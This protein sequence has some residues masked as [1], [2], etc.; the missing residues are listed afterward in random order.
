MCRDA[1]GLPEDGGEEPAIRAAVG[2]AS[3]WVQSVASAWGTD[4]V[5]SG[6]GDGTLKLWQVRWLRG[7]VHAGRSCARGLRPYHPLNSWLS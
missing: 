1:H 2:S 5:A 4:L 3:G 6:A 7:F